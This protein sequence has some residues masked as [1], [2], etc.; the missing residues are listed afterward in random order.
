VTGDFQKAKEYMGAYRWAIAYKVDVPPEGRQNITGPGLLEQIK[1]QD[2]R[3]RLASMMRFFWH[4]GDYVES[5]AYYDGHYFAINVHFG[6]CL[7]SL[8]EEFE[9]CQEIKAGICRFPTIA[10]PSVEQTFCVDFL[11]LGAKLGWEH[12]M[13]GY[14]AH[15]QDYP[16]DHV[17]SAFGLIL[18]D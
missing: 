5:A 14:C 4:I 7:L 11:K 1:S 8:C 15:A 3:H 10:K 6:P 2:G 18:I 13:W 16:K 17:P 9:T 12:H